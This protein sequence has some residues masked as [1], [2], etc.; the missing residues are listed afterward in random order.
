MCN[1]SYVTTF[2]LFKNVFSHFYW[3]VIDHNVKYK[4]SSCCLDAVNSAVFSISLYH[5]DGLLAAAPDWMLAVS[6]YSK[7]F[8]TI[9]CSRIPI[10]YEN[11]NVLVCIG[12][13]LLFCLQ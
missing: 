11:L 12:E 13:K 1:H 8:N 4:Y 3:N 7:S 2:F 10:T 5:C 9:Q 6:K